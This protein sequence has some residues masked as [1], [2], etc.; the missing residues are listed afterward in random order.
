[1]VTGLLLHWDAHIPKAGEARMDAPSA[2][3]ESAA[4]P[5][6]A[7]QPQH[8]RSSM[9]NSPLRNPVRLSVRT[10]FWVL[11]LVCYAACCFV[12][13]QGEATV[14][15]SII[16]FSEICLRLCGFEHDT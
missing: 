11:S 13:V 16:R 6:P 14:S 3:E 12:P 15:S 2:L 5:A 1:V 4:R 7:D 8:G 10:G 9:V